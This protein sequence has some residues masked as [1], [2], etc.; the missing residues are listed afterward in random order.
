MAT[1]DLRS[2]V[3]RAATVLLICGLALSACATRTH[4]AGY[5]PDDD[6]IAQIE[7][8][9]QK[10]TDVKRILGSPSSLASFESHNDTWYYIS[11]KTETIAFLSPE[12]VERSVVAVDFDDNGVVKQVRRFNL[13][14]GEDIEMVDRITPTRGK[15]LGFFEQM[16]GNFGRF[17][18]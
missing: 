2:S 13:E 3:L 12:I 1:P 10:Q 14:D 4:V 18:K 15:E 16:F 6:L 8:G 11:S 9:K 5:V 7:P 17:N